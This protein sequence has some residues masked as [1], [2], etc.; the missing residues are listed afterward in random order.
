MTDMNAI[1]QHSLG[2][3][4]LILISI[5]FGLCC[6]GQDVRIGENISPLILPP[7]ATDVN[8]S[9]DRCEELDYVVA[10]AYPGTN[11]LNF[12]SHELHKRG[13]SPVDHIERQFMRKPGVF[14]S[15][16]KWESFRNVA[17]TTTHTRAD[18]WSNSVGDVVSYNFWY[19]DKNHLSVL[20]LYCNHQFVVEHRCIPA[21][22][23][24]YDPRKH[25][26][27]I[28]ID[29][30]ESEGKDFKVSVTVKNIG[31]ESALVG[32]NGKLS[33]GKAELWVLSVE[34]EEGEDWEYVGSTCAEHPPLDWITL[35]PG[36][37]VESWAMAVDFP[38][39]NYRWAK[40]Q[41]KIAHLHG[42]IRASIYYYTGVCQ[43]TNPRETEAGHL[44]TS[45]PVTLPSKP[46]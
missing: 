42:R 29:R 7:S 45:E 38:E 32:F 1:R 6:L 9:D 46:Q 2:R 36:E 27:S 11:V 37:N 22:T 41:R 40:C 39:P 43:I 14:K 23:K 18:Q 19:E 28:D 44:A 15:A 20:A 4:G 12:I 33:D 17:G 26:L 16:A 8:R 21:A 25:R 3:L 35:K 34:Q 13:C 24:P 5:F 30:I 10:S 31:T